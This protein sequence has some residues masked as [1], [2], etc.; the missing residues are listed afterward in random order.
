MS[1][2]GTVIVHEL[3]KTCT[4]G[5]ECARLSEGFIEHEQA[6]LHRSSECELCPSGRDWAR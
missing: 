6:T 1:C 2:S 4:L 5:A 3:D